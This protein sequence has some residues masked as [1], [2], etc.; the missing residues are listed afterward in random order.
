MNEYYKQHPYSLLSNEN[1]FQLAFYSFFIMLG[2]VDASAEEE[3]LLGRIDVALT[4]KDDVYI[5]EMKLDGS[6][7]SA[8]KQIKD[9][10]YYDRYEESGKAI[11][12][13]GLSFSKKDKQI[14]EWKEEI[15]SI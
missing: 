15:L 2:D 8:I 1:N 14:E 6:A 10:R 9:K 7:D 3:T 5:I 13:V 11:H 4:Y 12:L